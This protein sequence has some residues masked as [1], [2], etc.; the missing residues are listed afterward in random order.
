[1]ATYN[2]NGITFNHLKRDGIEQGGWPF[3]LA[4]QIGPDE[5]GGV[6]NAVDIDWNSAILPNGNP[7]DASDLT[8]NTTGELLRMIINTGSPM[9]AN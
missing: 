4:G 6:V 5:D 2:Q 7:E 8:I 9:W 3:F 1:M